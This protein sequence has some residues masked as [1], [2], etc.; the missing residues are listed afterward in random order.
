M[1]CTPRGHLTR[2][3]LKLI[4]DTFITST[5]I[6]RFTLYLLQLQSY[7]PT[8]VCCM[9]FSANVEA[10]C[11]PVTHNIV[12]HFSILNF[13]LYSISI[14][15]TIAV[16][17]D[18]RPVFIALIW[19]VDSR[20]LSFVGIYRATGLIGLIFV[21]LRRVHSFWE[22]RAL[23]LNYCRHAVKSDCRQS[24]GCRLVSLAGNSIKEAI[25]RADLSENV[26]VWQHR[27]L[28]IDS[29]H[30]RSLP[31]HLGLYRNTDSSMYAQFVLEA[32]QSA[33]I[34]Q[35]IFLHDVHALWTHWYW[36]DV[37]LCLTVSRICMDYADN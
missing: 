12:D 3:G 2:Y 37:R 23:S 10:T 6:I 24:H 30:D 5:T 9:S 15:C 17:L 8:C 32:H 7:L 13:G 4:S 18:F 11:L 16:Q 21:L 27:F 35:S 28:S 25:R 31:S 26:H 1:H 36:I 34:V 19:H 20:P 33:C 14:P 29:S 22:I